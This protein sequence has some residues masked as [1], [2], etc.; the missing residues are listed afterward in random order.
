MGFTVVSVT[1]GSPME[2]TQVLINAGS[3]EA[4]ERA[5]NLPFDYLLLQGAV[6]PGSGDAVIYVG[7]DYGK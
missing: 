2:R 4:E 5:A 7:R 6:S 1:T 3:R